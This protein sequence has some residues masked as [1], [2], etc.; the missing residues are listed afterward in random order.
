MI[1]WSVVIPMIIYL[2]AMIGV[3]FYAN[4]K[5]SES[6]DFISEYYIGS[7]SFGAMV[8][9]M[10]LVVTFASG[11]SFLGGPGAASAFGYGWVF[12]GMIQIPT[13]YLTLGVLGKK[14]AIVSRRINAVTVLD[15]LKARYNSSLYIILSA[16]VIVGFFLGIMVAQWM[17]GATLI[18]SVSG[19]SYNVALVIFAI[20]V[21]IY[22]TFGGFRAVALSDLIQGVVMF[23][24]AIVL[25]I[26]II[27]AGGGVGALTSALESEAPGLVS[28]FGPE[29]S[30]LNAAMYTIS[31]WI[32]VGFGL[33]GLPHVGIRAM[34]Y[35]DANSMARAMVIGTIVV[36]FIM[37]ALH[38]AG[39]WG[40]V[41][42]PEIAAGEITGDH[43]IPEVAQ[44]VMPAWLAGI[45]LAGPL[46]AIMSTVDSILILVSSTIVKDVYIGYVNKN[47]KEVSVKAISIGFTA[48]LA[49]LVFL[50]SFEQIPL[51]VI[52]NLFGL[53]GL[54]AFFL[55][56]MLLGLFWRKAN[57]QGALSA[58][59]VG[60]LFYGIYN[61]GW[62]GLSAPLG[63]HPVLFPV[64]YSLIVFVVVS[65]LTKGPTEKT[66][67]LFWGKNPVKQED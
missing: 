41:L 60:V 47:P 14:F 10:T 16:I 32:L 17:A 33:L 25:M 48:A 5:R 53:G 42:V 13:A 23:F 3:A 35:K 61:Q 24:G 2:A 12:L 20:V 11:S 54:Q 4:K 34:S 21:L 1:E 36:G 50:L 46:A 52:L 19:L 15:M 43:V 26:A 40:R 66:L 63:S 55:W 45:I 56:P 57:Y 58:S 30:P 29:G 22:V 62:F 7:K 59:L 39:A 6:K 38:L 44:R 8:L 49:V 67:Q 9:A 51:I 28:P 65:Y 27:A 31:F 64:I 37:L 18:S